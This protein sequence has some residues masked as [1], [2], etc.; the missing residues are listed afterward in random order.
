VNH[1]LRVVVVAVAALAAAG[2]EKKTAIEQLTSPEPAPSTADPVKLEVT[3]A[4]TSVALGDDVVLHFK[5]TNAGSTPVQV[6]VPR[7]DQRSVTL[8][9]RRADGSVAAIS[10][11]HADIDNR[12]GRFAYQAADA[13][14][15][16]P[17]QSLEQ[18]VAVVAVEAGKAAFT[19]SYTRQGAPAA[20]TAPT[21]EVDVAPADASK[22]RLGVTLDT[23]HGS[24]TAVFRPDIAYNTVES[25]SS[26]VKRGFYTGVKFHRMMP[27]FMAQAG[28][29]TGTGEGGPGY[30]IQ[31]EAQT[32]K[33]PHKRGVMSMARTGIP[34]IGRQTAG[35][36][37]FL[38]F[39]TRKDLDDMRND[40][41]YT[42]F[43]EMTDGEETLKKLQAVPLG[44][45]SQGEPSAPREAVLIKS[46]KLV[47]LP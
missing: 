15:L 24:Y 38:M 45:N 46:A 30:F 5:L 40:G 16:A 21:I 19:P 18:D 32:A 33:L 36:Q 22:P 31:F 7:I 20:L 25:F 4:K 8:R 14:T 3:A 27:D 29:P 34:G 42:T 23:T 44:P 13:K 1:A 9:V 12:T 41:G 35:S 26:L 47:Q 17:G 43:A 28:D 39:A 10:R 2:C 11:N 6:N 37:F